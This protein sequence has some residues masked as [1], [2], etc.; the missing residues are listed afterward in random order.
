MQTWQVDPS[1]CHL[2]HVVDLLAHAGGADGAGAGGALTGLPAGPAVVVFE[3]E[4]RRTTLVA[5]T[6]DAREFVRKRLGATPPEAGDEAKRSRRV[7]HRVL[8]RRVTVV[9]V[10]SAF[11]AEL[12]YV[13]QVR[14]RLPAEYRAA[15]ER[16]RP[17]WVRVDPGDEFPDLTKTNLAG[18]SDAAPRR[19]GGNRPARTGPGVLVGPVPDKDAAGRLIEAVVDVADLCRFH[20][21]L[22]QAPRATACAYKEMGRCPAPCD[23]T[24]TMDSYRA[25]V[26][27]ALESLTVPAEARRAAVES[28]MRDDAARQDFEGAQRRQKVLDR[29]RALEKPAFARV[30]TITRFRWLL[31]TAGGRRGWARLHVCVGG[32]VLPVA[33]VDGA[34]AAGAARDLC[35]CIVSAVLSAPAMELGAPEIDT[36]ALVCRWLSLAARKKRVGVVS[37]Q[38]VEEEGVDARGVSLAIRRACNVPPMDERPEGMEMDTG[39]AQGI[40]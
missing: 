38:R 16:W 8:T 40:A 10:G 27:A 23:G 20:H 34:G 36:M 17:W 29:L 9:P 19:A 28:R 18:A 39:G 5:T 12:E 25:R 2:T 26:G 22:V 3:G 30:S 32:N 13:R 37:L 15:V 6:A 24:E 21:L 33:D 7:D 4:G 14:A 35:G 1:A 11:E 31:A